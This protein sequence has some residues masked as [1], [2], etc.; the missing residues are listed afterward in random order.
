MYYI[1]EDTISNSIGSF[2]SFEDAMCFAINYCLE[3]DFDMEYFFEKYSNNKDINPLHSIR[4]YLEYTHNVYIR[5]ITIETTEMPKFDLN[6][7]P[8]ISNYLILNK[9]MFIS[10]IGSFILSQ[11]EIE[12][13]EKLLIFK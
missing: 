7:I 2:D 12:K 9:N 6:R 1:Y 4:N 5:D 10:N 8:E 13:I 3:Q 11:E